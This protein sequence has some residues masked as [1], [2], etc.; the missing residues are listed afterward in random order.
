M[1]QQT[2]VEWYAIEHRKLLIQL[3]SKELSLGE[4]VVKH[5]DILEQAKQMEK[6]Q[7]EKA[8]KDYPQTISIN[9][10]GD[11]KLLSADQYYNKTYTTRLQNE[12]Y[13]K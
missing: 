2:A 7:I 12:T 5:Q 9:D 4:Y 1:A 13:G 6:E 10:N 11:Y 8:Y 3:E